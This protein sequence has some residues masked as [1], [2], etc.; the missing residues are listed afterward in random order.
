MPIAGT[1]FTETSYHL[2][3]NKILLLFTFIG[4]NSQSIASFFTD[5]NDEKEKKYK[6]N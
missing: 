1:L 4:S 5:L 3:S 2:G 6:L